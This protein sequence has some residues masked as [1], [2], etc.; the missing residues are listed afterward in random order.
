ME[1]EYRKKGDILKSIRKGQKL[2]LKE[3]DRGWSN[4]KSRKK[5]VYKVEKG[6]REND[7]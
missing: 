5:L 6:S 1:R 7:S 2:Q 3:G 4:Q